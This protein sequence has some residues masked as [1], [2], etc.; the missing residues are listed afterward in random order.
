[1]SLIERFYYKIWHDWLKLDKPITNITK[2]EQ[3]SNP[4]LFLLIFAGLG[5]FVGLKLRRY[6]WQLLAG[7]LLGIVV[8]HIFW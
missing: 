5:L 4:L 7:F 6:W 8:G 2:E 1:M 3:R